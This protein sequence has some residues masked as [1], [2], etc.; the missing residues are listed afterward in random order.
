MK[1]V[2]ATLNARYAHASFGLRYLRANLGKFREESKICEF[3]IKKNPDEI[4]TE[5]LAQNPELVGFGVY[6]WNTIQTHEVIR[7]LREKKPNLLIVA[8]GPEVSFETET[9][10]I[11]QDL[12]YV[13]KGEADFTFSEFVHQYF[14]KSERPQSKIIGP[15]LPKIDQIVLPYQEY[16][17]EDLRHRTLYV[18]ASRGCPYKCEY[19]LSSLDISVRNFTLEP[20]LNEMQKLLDRGARQFKFVDRT[21]NL[22]PK[23]STEILKFFL[24]RI[25]LGLFLHFEMVPDRLPEEL[26]E[27]IKQFPAGALQ[28]EIGI[29]TWNPEVAKNVSRRQNYEKIAENFAFLKNETGVH[30][31]ADLIIGLPGET[32]ESF[33]KGFEQLASLGPDEV[34]VG[35]L[36]RLKGAPLVRHEKTFS[37]IYD[38]APPFQILE[39]KDLNRE[40]IQK[41]EIFAD[42]WDVLAN[43]GK[44]PRVMSLIRAKNSLFQTMYEISLSLF[45]KFGRTHSIH[46]HEMDLALPEVLS[47]VLKCDLDAAE[48]AVQRDSKIRKRPELA[49]E[50]AALPERQRRHQTSVQNQNS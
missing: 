1:I 40:Q 29:Q 32:I 41:L 18:E 25:D 10:A 38:S 22:S 4:A 9:Q 46:L 34:Q 37:M 50:L 11:Y 30:T 7:R 12:D 36:K 14:D 39:N 48:E 5:I 13:F 49:A 21:F 17:D 27:L 26:K 43:S 3:T 28:F 16:T 31:H 20:F 35:L 47:Q 8:G 24:D 6:I 2:L 15:S 23:I 45:T 19:C 44:Y 33:A 42:F